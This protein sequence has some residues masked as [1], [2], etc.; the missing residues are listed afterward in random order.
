MKATLMPLNGKY[1]GTKIAITDDA[2]N[3]YEVELWN[4][5][6]W[7]PSDRELD[8]ACSI[9]EWRENK[10]LPIVDHPWYPNGIPAKEAVE[11]CDSHFESRETYT[12]AL[13]IVRRLNA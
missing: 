7:E 8:G 11:I 3:E 12:L 4:M 1:Y 2:G 13:E 10:I 9:D 6:K 5:G